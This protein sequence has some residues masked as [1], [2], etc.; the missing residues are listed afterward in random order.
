M[1]ICVSFQ[2]PIRTQ[3]LHYVARSGLASGE[4]PSLS[5][6][7]MSPDNSVRAHPVQVFGTVIMQRTSVVADEAGLRDLMRL[8]PSRVSYH[9]DCVGSPATALDFLHASQPD[10]VLL[11]PIH[12]IS[13]S[14]AVAAPLA[15]W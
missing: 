12:W 4:R 10:A 8:F 6:C 15:R 7:A 2:M 9:V 14:R 5:G 1:P 3:S 11:G 13:P